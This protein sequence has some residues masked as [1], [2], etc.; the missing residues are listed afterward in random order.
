MR[1]GRHAGGAGTS[2]LR[3][4]PIG[5][6]EQVAHGKKRPHMIPLERFPNTSNKQPLGLVSLASQKN[7][8][9]VYLMNMYGDPE[10]KSWFTKRYKATGKRLDMGKSCVRF[11]TLDELPV[12]LIGETVAR[13]PVDAFLEQ[14]LEA[15]KLAAKGR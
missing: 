3:H 10:T 12:E 9:A 15:R 14:Y 2:G 7:Y 13:T 1:L 4:V 6:E 8:M 5:Q 11:R